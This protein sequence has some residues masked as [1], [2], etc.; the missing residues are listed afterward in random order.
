MQICF[1][2]HNEN[3]VKELNEIMPDGFK[4]IGLDEM[5]IKEEIAETGDTLEENS[6]IKARYIFDQYKTP[7]VSD[8]SGLLVNALN[9]EP[10]VYS[11]RYAGQKKDADDNMDLLLKKLSGESDR[12]AAFQTIVTYI[13]DTGN[14]HQFKGEIKGS[15]L[16]QKRGANGFGYDPIF[17]PDGFEESFAELSSEVKNRISHRAKAVQKLLE[18]L[19]QAND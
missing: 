13:D 16:T 11:A 10:G 12:S 1:A 17:Q 18:H 8:D 3:K 9:G 7:V 5:G 6:R 2:S 15:I 19:H 14:E 4:I